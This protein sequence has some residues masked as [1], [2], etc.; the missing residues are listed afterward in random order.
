[1]AHDASKVL[2]G[3]TRSSSKQGSEVFAS[4][5]ATFVAGL[6][7]RRTNAGALS[8]AL[9]AGNWV[10]VSLGKSLSD[11]AKT[12]VLK[13]GEQVP[14]LLTAAFTPTIGAAVYISDVTGKGIASGD[15]TTVSNAVYVSGL[16]SGIN[17][18]GESVPC[19]IIDMPGG[20]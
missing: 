10:G 14:L 5:P 20:L 2:L 7:V 13:A 15:D 11:N 3:T 19:A 6:A 17:E 1:M 16:M 18:A 4:D 8:V 12:E 9:A